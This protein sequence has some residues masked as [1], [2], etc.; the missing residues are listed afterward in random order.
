M[1]NPN[2]PKPVSNYEHIENILVELTPD[3]REF[4]GQI[5]PVEDVESDIKQLN[6]LR[7]SPNYRKSEERSDAKILE[8]T[9]IDMV[10]LGDWFNEEE[11]Y[12]EDPDYLA[13]VT[14]PTADVD[15]A[16]N[17]IDVVGMIRN[18]ETRHE[19]MPFA[20]D[21]TY[22]TDKVKM[23]Q[24]FRWKHVYGKKNTAP[25][26]VSEFG[27]SYI[28]KDYFGRDILKTR[29]L[30]LKFRYGLKIPG[31]VSAK[32]YED[33]SNPWDPIYQK[34]RIDLMPRFIVGYSTD[35]TD[36]LSSGMPTN[37]YR[38][39]YGEGV[40]QK[41]KA[42]YK[43]AERCAKWCT[44]FECREQASDI[45]FMLERLDDAERRW[46]HPEELKNAKEQII[47]MEKYFIK[48]IEIATKKA[49]ND[50]A[51]IAA[52]D[53]SDRDAVRQAIALHSNDT[54]IMGN[55]K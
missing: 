18:K 3:P 11:I 43:N 9:F 55:W 42:K 50:P 12:G 36:I 6:D 22:N 25:E 8:K 23:A 5:Y 15:D 37:E 45:R 2:A 38:K 51:E 29:S 16:F 14:C 53:Y 28:D 41:E 46:M 4:E 44:L 32:Y 17:H 54:Y 7:R 48:A 19:T 30:P 21:L 20:I 47:T 31:F 1:L 39:K 27:Y 40:Y 35:I 49:Q 10:E 13:L 26:R 24:K 52:M 33:K 34:G